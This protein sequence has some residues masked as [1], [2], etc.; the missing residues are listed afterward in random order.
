MCEAG[1]TRVVTVSNFESVIE[2]VYENQ[3]RQISV[4]HSIH[5]K[6]FTDFLWFLEILINSLPITIANSVKGRAHPHNNDMVVFLPHSCY[7]QE[8]APA[9]HVKFSFQSYKP[10]INT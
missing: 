10:V 6:Y 5:E 9:C 2:N 1:E 4:W 7:V 8:V 3:D